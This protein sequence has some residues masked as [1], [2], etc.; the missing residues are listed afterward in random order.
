MTF[1]LEIRSIFISTLG[2]GPGKGASQALSVPNV[3]M[4]IFAQHHNRQQIIKL[5]IKVDIDMVKSQV[6]KGVLESLWKLEVHLSKSA[7]LVPKHSR[8]F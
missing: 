2:A 3:F 7:D 4:R 8:D 1:E 6:Q 5:L